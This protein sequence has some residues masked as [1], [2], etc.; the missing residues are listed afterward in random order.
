MPTIEISLELDAI[1]PTSGNAGWNVVQGQWYE[2]VYRFYRGAN[3]GP[4]ANRGL[5]TF[6]TNIPKNLAGT[7][8]WNLVLHHVN[9][10]GD[11]GAVLLRVEGSVLASGDTPV[12]MTVLVPNQLVGVDISGDQNIT[13][14]SGTNFDSLLALTAG[15]KLTIQVSR[16]PVTASGDSLVG[17]WDLLLPPLLRCDVT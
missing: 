2:G 9:A 6:K 12:A 8:A 1:D 7:P 10:S 5:M 17:N 15:N 3:A 11:Q 16:M 4:I 14:L 13:A